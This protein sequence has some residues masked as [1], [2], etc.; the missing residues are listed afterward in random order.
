MQL[1]R[2]DLLYGD[3]ILPQRGKPC[4]LKITKLRHDVVQGWH[5]AAQ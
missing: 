2:Y 5:D 1:D 3:K 4:I